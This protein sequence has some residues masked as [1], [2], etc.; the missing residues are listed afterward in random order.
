M[1]IVV[2]YISLCFDRSHK[3]SK[4][5]CQA[6]SKLPFSSPLPKRFSL[7]RSTSQ[8][9]RG[10]VLKQ[11]KGRSKQLNAES[12]ARNEDEADLAKM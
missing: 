7:Q 9:L 1:L 8:C 11:R 12:I 2:T 4:D 3:R 6:P 10:S 5:D